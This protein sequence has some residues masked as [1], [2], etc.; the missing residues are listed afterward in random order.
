S[1]SDPVSG[2]WN[3]ARILIS[4][5]LPA[6]LSPS[7][8]STSP[9]RRCR[10]MSRRATVGPNRLPTC[11]TRS[12]SSSDVV[13]STIFSRSATAGPRSDAGDEGV[14]GHRQDDRDADVEEL[15]VGVDALEDQAV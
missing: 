5:D 3:P 6:P 13:G 15:V 10:L 11:S 12:T 8:P 2:F 7:R 4:V 9:L 1:H 14:D